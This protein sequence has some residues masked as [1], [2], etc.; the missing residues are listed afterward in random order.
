MTVPLHPSMMASFLVA[1]AVRSHLFLDCE[2]FGD[3]DPF[4]ELFCYVTCF[5]SHLKKPD[6][7]ILSSSFVIIIKSWSRLAAQAGKK[8]N[9]HIAAF[10]TLH[11]G[12]S[13]YQW[14]WSG[15]GQHKCTS[16]VSDHSPV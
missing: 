8:K 11:L 9:F 4:I 16:K 14:G 3:K 5:V 12:N 15:T 7:I 10:K 1:L 2:H 6:F 13:S